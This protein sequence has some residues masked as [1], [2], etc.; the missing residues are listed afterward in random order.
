MKL[1][2]KILPINIEEEIK[3]SYLDYAMSVIIGRALPDV[4]DGLKPVHRRILY[5]MRELGNDYNKPYKKSARVVGD[6]MGKYHPHGDAA[7]YDAL[8]R[9]AQDFSMR[10]PLV[11]GQGNF[12]SV[13]GDPAAAM[14]YTEA[15]MAKLTQ[16]FLSDIDKKTVDFVDNYDGSMQ[17]PTVLPA[18]APNLLINGSSGIA[19][20][21]ATNIPPHNLG[22]VVDGLIALIHN[23]EIT[24]TQLMQHIPGP[25]FPTSGFLYG[26]QGLLD[27]YKTGRGIIKIRGRVNTE[28]RPRDNKK[29]IVVSEIPYQVN[30]SRLL[31]N[32]SDLIRDKK[33]DGISELRDESDRDGLRVI[34]EVKRDFPP[35]VIINQ[36]YRMTQ[37]EV[38]FGINTLAIVN[39]VP[40][41]LSLKEALEYFLDHRR[42]VIIKRTKFELAKAEARAHILEGYKKA[43]DQLDLVIELIRASSSPATARTRLMERL[44]FTEI[45]AQAI[46]ELRLQKLTALERKSIDDE[47]L[48][49]IKDI[50]HYRDIL[51]NIRLVYQ[52]IEEEL[53][54]LKED[55]NDPRRTEII[56]EHGPDLTAEDLIVEEDMVVTISH[57]GYIKRNPISL[58]RAQRRGGR[59][60]T[61]TVTKEEDFVE[62]LYVASTHSYL[63]FLTSSGR[64][65]WMKVHEVP[66]AGRM[67][68]GKAM[69]NLLNLESG[70]TVATVLPVRDLTEA[71]RFVV[72]ATRNG[73]IKRTEL[74]AFSHPKKVGIIALTINEGDELVSA[75]LTNGENV[76]F[77]ATRSGKAISFSEPEI[78]AMG[79]TA[80]GVRGI[81]LSRD[82]V[83]V[84]MEV[85]KS[86]LQET[87]LTVTANGFGKRTI[88]SDYRLQARGG[89]GLITI[90]TT[91]RNGP[92]VGAFNVEEEEQ[93]MLI[94]DTGRIIRIRAKEIPIIGRN[95]QGVTLIDVA[96]GE[97]VVGVAP[98]EEQDEE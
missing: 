48:Q 17:E 55:Y 4:R 56:S 73:Q 63:L 9:M 49:L 25:D 38:S 67:A 3:G 40:R 97:R 91:L 93:L 37:L 77:L 57:G 43:L 21:M 24:V 22:E 33:I 50:A 81:K 95:T 27:A 88:A 71:N 89:M 79:R 32:I 29:T 78:R 18:R 96:P 36:L 28:T 85:L 23:P 70:E 11:D 87:I 14:R 16:E 58:Y 59:G 46:L 20:G 30:K 65:H 83:V 31:E 61:G 13:D 35:E 82:D 26:G 41:L 39:Q 64:L 80:A 42:E 54:T 15:R 34:M 90:K 72:M 60:I 66:Q 5:T 44:D 86:E 92:V 2:E 19:V 7:I 62:R 68:R 8:V 10:Y 76:I 74:G 47:Y 1:F 12:G 51:G 53:V 98:V 52:I 94:T 6:V 84:G 45:Q 69:V 75:A